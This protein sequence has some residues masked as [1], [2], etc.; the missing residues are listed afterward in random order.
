MNS[1]DRARDGASKTFIGYVKI[2]TTDDFIV[3]EIKG[4]T[5]KSARLR[6]KKVVRN[7][8]N[9][10]PDT[11]FTIAHVFD[12]EDDTATELRQQCRVIE[13]RKTVV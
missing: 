5:R 11:Q 2:G 12:A 1:H 13:E 3:Y 9:E 8:S 7:L 6:L 10:D 4:L